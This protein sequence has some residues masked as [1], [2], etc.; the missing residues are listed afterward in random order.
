[1]KLIIY[2]VSITLGLLSAFFIAFN[3]FIPL[4]QEFPEYIILISFANFWM[5]FYIGYKIFDICKYLIKKLN[6]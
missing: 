6:K 1:M 4:Q 5:N 3:I 2:F